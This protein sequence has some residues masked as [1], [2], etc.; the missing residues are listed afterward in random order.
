MEANMR[1]RFLS[2][3]RGQLRWTSE[4]DESTAEE[5]QAEKD[6]KERKWKCAEQQRETTHKH[7]ERRGISIFSS[8]SLYSISVSEYIL[9]AVCVNRTTHTQK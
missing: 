4:R 2:R 7:I 3:T 8:I 6:K 9:R 1:L 5:V